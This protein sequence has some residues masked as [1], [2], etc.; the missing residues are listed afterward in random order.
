MFS[1]SPDATIRIWSV[2]NASC[3]QVVRAH[4]SAVTGLSLHAT[5][6]YLL[7]SSDDQVSSQPGSWSPYS[8]ILGGGNILPSW[9]PRTR[10]EYFLSTERGWP[11]QGL[12]DQGPCLPEGPSEPGD[13]LSYRLCCLFL[14]STGPSLTSRQDVC[15]PR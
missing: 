4:E 12:P 1:A 8:G 11:C 6:D 7:S 5:G 10:R 3:V 14:F 13:P 15:S 2:P 9:V